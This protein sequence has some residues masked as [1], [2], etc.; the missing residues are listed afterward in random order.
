[1]ASKTLPCTACRYELFLTTL[2]SPLFHFQQPAMTTHKPY[3][4]FFQP[5]CCSIDQGRT[6]RDKGGCS[7]A[8]LRGNLKPRK[9]RLLRHP[10]EVAKLKRSSNSI[11]NPT[12]G[13]RK[14]STLAKNVTCLLRIP[15]A[16]N[17][18]VL[19]ACVSEETEHKKGNCSM[20]SQHETA[21]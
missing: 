1:M 9:E 7:L 11:G 10:C 15:A 3:S 14:P 19:E 12:L 8:P 5:A 6:I 21:C 13:Q 16:Q 2:R 4:S 18:A 20:G 17:K